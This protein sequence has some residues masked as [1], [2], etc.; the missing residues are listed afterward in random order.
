MQC[1]EHLLVFFLTLAKNDQLH[2]V[3]SDN[4]P[5]AFGNNIKT[6]VRCQTG[7]DGKKRNILAFGESDFLLHCEFIL[8][9][10]CHTCGRKACKKSRILFG[11]VVG[12][13]NAVE[14]TAQLVCVIAQAILKTVCIFGGFDLLCIAGTHRGNCI[15]TLDGG[16]H[17]IDATVALH[18]GVILFAKREDISKDGKIVFALVLDVVNGENRFDACKLGQRAVKTV[19]INN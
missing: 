14:N 19:E 12:V 9:L 7:N 10:S 13:V 18:Q 4:A 5:D 17:Q 6:L 11:I 1:L 8:V 15:G 3:I 16:F 2:V